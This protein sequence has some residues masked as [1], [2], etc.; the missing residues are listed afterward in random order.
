MGM[1]REIVFTEKKTPDDPIVLVEVMGNKYQ[2]KNDKTKKDEKVRILNIRMK[3]KP[4]PDT[5]AI[6]QTIVGKDGQSFVSNVYY[7]ED[8]PKYS[9][10]T[11]SLKA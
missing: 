7:T 10:G 9:G 6:K 1:Y 4:L 8:L 3:R 5:F 11:V 2:L